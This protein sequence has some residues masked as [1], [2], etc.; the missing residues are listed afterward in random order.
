MF[1]QRVLYVVRPSLLSMIK[2]IGRTGIKYGGTV[3][4]D[5][6]QYIQYKRRRIWRTPDISW[7]GGKKIT[8]DLRTL[9][10]L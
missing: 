7:A 9:N 3:V 4:V 8:S 5:Q 10:F 2:N 6:S 1:D